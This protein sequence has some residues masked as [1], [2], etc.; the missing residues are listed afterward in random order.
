MGRLLLLSSMLLGLSEAITVEVLRLAASIVAGI[1]SLAAAY[2]ARQGRVAARGARREAR[3]ARWRV[4]DPDR[5]RVIV[6]DEPLP[7]EPERRR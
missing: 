7:D 1:C 3:R 6:V 2:W 4:R 5:E